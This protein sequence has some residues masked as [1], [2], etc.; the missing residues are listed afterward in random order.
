MEAVFKICSKGTCGIEITGLERDGNQYKAEDNNIQSIRTYK[1]TES[2]TLNVIMS[3]SYDG[4]Q[5]IEAIEPVTHVLEGIDNVIF[6]YNK[7]GIHKIVH[8]IL[9]TQKLLNDVSLYTNFIYYDEANDLIKMNNEEITVEQL[10]EIEPADD[11]TIIRADKQTFCICYL[12]ECYYRICKDL[13]TKF[14]GKCINK[15]QKDQQEVYNRDIVWM[16]ISVIKY[17]IEFGQ[18]NEAQRILEAITQCGNICGNLKSKDNNS[19]G[20]S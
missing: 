13:L 11:N 4:T 3:V 7:D 10:L 20:C 19:C 12:N 14:C 8:I 18:Y 17:L 1:Y 5:T 15:L 16:T 2:I 6:N 9:P